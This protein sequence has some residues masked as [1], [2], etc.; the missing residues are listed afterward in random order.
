[1]ESFIALQEKHRKIGKV[2]HP[3][4]PPENVHGLSQKIQGTCFKISAL[5]FKIY[6][7]YFPPFQMPKKQCL[8]K[9]QKSAFTKRCLGYSFSDCCLNNSQSSLSFWD[10]S[11][12]NSKSSLSFD[13]KA[14]DKGE[15][16]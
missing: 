6:G 14:D 15:H 4:S 2:S 7:L 3:E 12:N 10:C 13:A 9:G 11:L 16:P 8:E 1:M 5:Y